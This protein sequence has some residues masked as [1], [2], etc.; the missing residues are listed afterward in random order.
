[1]KKVILSIMALFSFTAFA[2]E[3]FV[4]IGSDRT[5]RSLTVTWEEQENSQNTS[6]VNLTVDVEGMDSKTYWGLNSYAP[7]G[8]IE[9]FD[10]MVGNKSLSLSL[11]LFS[12][13]T[14]R[15]DFYHN[16]KFLEKDKIMLNCTATDL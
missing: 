2:S 8:E 15:G 3:D 13:G 16:G 7:G 10:F 5:G 6:R 9:G 4:C 12:D 1:M 14:I 11:Y